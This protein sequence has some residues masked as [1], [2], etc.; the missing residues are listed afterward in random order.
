MPYT[1]LGPAT[2]VKHESERPMSIAWRLAHP[3]PAEMFEE[4]KVA[5]GEGGALGVAPR[6]I[7]ASRVPTRSQHQAL[8]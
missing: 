1:F 3:M 2:Y 7:W 5:T 6:E 4:T 8:Q